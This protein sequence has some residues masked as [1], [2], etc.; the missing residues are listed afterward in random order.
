MG[1]ARGCWSGDEKKGGEGIGIVGFWRQGE[2]LEGVLEGESLAS[3]RS[4]SWSSSSSTTSSSVS[5]R[6]GE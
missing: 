6:G 2:W 5:R 3:S 4:S 1:P